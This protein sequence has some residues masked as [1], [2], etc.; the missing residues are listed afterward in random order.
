[1]PSR[2]ALLVRSMPPC[3][4]NTWRALANPISE[5][6]TD[7]SYGQYTQYPCFL[8][9]KTFTRFDPEPLDANIASKSELIDIEA[10]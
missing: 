3:S 7:R 1:M 6:V 8:S 2:I 9:N 5:V 4:L 10:N